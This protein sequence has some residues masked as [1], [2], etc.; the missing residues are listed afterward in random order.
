VALARAVVEQ[1]GGVLSFTSAPGQGTIA[2]IRLP[3][4]A[5]PG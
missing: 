2:T 5:R 1:H 3:P 4:V